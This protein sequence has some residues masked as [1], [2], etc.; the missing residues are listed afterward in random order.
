VVVG[1]LGV[2][3]AHHPMLLSGLRRMQTDMGDTRF[4]NYMLEHCY[5]WSI[6][7]PHH[8]DVWSPPFFYPK[9][10]A[11][12]Y[13][14]LFLGVA[15]LYGAIRA[16]GL[17]PDTSF[18]IWM[19]A[20]SCL[21][22]TVAFH[23]LRCRLRLS[24][25]AASVGAFLFAFGAPR[26]NQMG[27][28]QL[29]PQFLGLIT[30]DALFGIFPGH[31]TTALGRSWLWFAAA[32][33]LVAQLYAGFYLGW[34][35]LLALGVAAGVALIWPSTRGAFLAAL[36]RDA[37]PAAAATILSCL[38]LRPLV[39]HYLLA[40]HEVGPRYYSE[41]RGFLPQWSDLFYHG[42]ESWL[43]GWPCRLGIAP[44]ECEGE[45]RLGIGLVT[46]LACTLGIYWN[47]GR[48]SIR[49]VMAVALILFLCAAP[50]PHGLALGLALSVALLALAGL[51]HDPGDDPWTR[52]LASGL[53]LA[54]LRLNPFA[55]ETVLGVGLFALL[56]VL[57]DL[58]RGGGSPRFRV[59]LGGLA[60]GLGMWL[61]APLVLAVGAGLGGLAACAAAVLRVRPR[62]RIGLVAVVVW[63]L[64]AA[65]TTY[66]GR[67]TV[68]IVGGSAPLLLALTRPARRRPPASTLFVALSFALLALFLLRG[69]IPAWFTLSSQVPGGSALRAVGRVGL[70]LLISWSIG[71]GLFVQAM[72]ARRRPL[73]A[74]LVVLVCLLEQGMTTES[75]DKDE[76]RAAVAAL[77]R[78]IDRRDMAF[79]YSPRDAQLLLYRYHLDAMWGGLESGVPTIN[80][81]SGN[82]PPDW[83]LLYFTNIKE[84]CDALCLDTL[85]RRWIDRRGLARDR[86]GWVG[87]PSEWQQGRAKSSPSASTPGA[88]GAPD[89]D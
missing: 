12:A 32:L 63:L 70:M 13:S 79:Y 54:S 10:N 48:P 77:A 23:L 26:I 30:V 24:P 36:R 51:Y 53:V 17:P 87:G 85:L 4:N 39:I 27:H 7:A 41:V 38:A 33:G 84:E 8:D 59:L 57:A 80:G 71:L 22:F 34:F 15:P 43:W 52:V 1:A 61:F 81:Y 73:G 16:A 89:G 21:N 6:G 5:R 68:L 69:E 56:I 58:Y 67:P 28:Q 49:L 47:W 46:M 60:V 42:P 88:R 62:R 82:Y 9:R 3:M 37:L 64:F 76:H 44:A 11:A 14:D 66:D 35:L 2:L 18:Q 20:V 72:L 74:L 40:A 25:T 83:S 65:L 78:R 31:G 29:L 75:Y 86:V 19:I 55:S 50:V 45:R